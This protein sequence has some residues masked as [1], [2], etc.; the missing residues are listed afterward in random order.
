MWSGEWVD[1]CSVQ[2]K[3]NFF[4]P[5]DLKTS[6]SAATAAHMGSPPK[7]SLLPR[8]DTVTST[9]PGTGRRAEAAETAR[10]ALERDNRELKAELLAARML[11]QEKL[12]RTL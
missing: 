8:L 4:S 7:S 5:R 11:L 10:R 12:Q 1:C 3:L 2:S 9:P 6:R